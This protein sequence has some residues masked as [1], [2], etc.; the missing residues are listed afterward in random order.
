MDSCYT[1]DVDETKERLESV[2]PALDKVLLACAAPAMKASMITG[3]NPG[4]IADLC[5][6]DVFLKAAGNI[7]EF[8]LEQ[9]V[10]LTSKDH[11][12]FGT[13]NGLV[14]ENEVSAVAINLEVPTS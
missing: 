5:G 4:Q 1:H 7:E 8:H 2:H 3:T 9:S 13:V 14:N 11:K 10:S 12:I 6:K